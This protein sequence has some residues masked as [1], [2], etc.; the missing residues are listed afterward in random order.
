[1]NVGIG[2]YSAIASRGEARRRFLHEQGTPLFR[3]SWDRVVFIHYQVPPD[4]LQR[5]VPFDLDVHSGSAYVSLVAFTLRNL[6]P[7]FGGPIVR[8]A[9]LPMATQRFLNVRTYVTSD[10]EPG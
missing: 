8:W 2:R 4:L 6:R 7:T 5:S 9:T 1:M 10:V 3:C